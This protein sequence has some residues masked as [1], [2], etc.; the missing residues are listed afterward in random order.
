MSVSDY[1]H[2]QKLDSTGHSR[3]Q[4][5]DAAYHWLQE[6]P[7]N[8]AKINDV[9]ISDEE[10]P[11]LQTQLL[12]NWQQGQMA[13]ALLCLRC[14]VSHAILRAC[15]QLVSQFGDSYQFASTDLLPFVLD[16]DG[17]PL[18]AYQPLG[19]HIVETYTPGKTSLE[20]WAGHLTRNHSELNQFLIE[21]GLYRV[22]DW[23]I[24][25]DTRIE[26]LP[27]ILGEFHRLTASEIDAAKVL[28]DSYHRVY[29]R[30]RLQLSKDRKRGRCQVP[31]DRQ[32]QAIDPKTPPRIALSQLRQLAYW[33]R[34]YRI[35]VRG[36]APPAV[37]L[38]SED[39]WERAAP[40][41][42]DSEIQQDEFLQIYHQQFETALAEAMTVTLQAY[43]D[44]LHRKQPVKADKFL[45][46]LHL[47]H[48]EGKAMKAIAP[49]VGL[50][51]QVQ[52]TR[53]MNLRRFRADVRSELLT[54]LQSR[55]PDTVLAFTSPEQL[56]KI[57]DYLDALLAEEGDRLV[58]E[59]ES[60]AKIPYNRAANSRFAQ[61]LCASLR[62]LNSSKSPLLTPPC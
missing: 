48:C 60:E 59:A 43:Y 28:L 41:R 53:L 7:P 36:G 2:L 4:Q 45:K 25:N 62:H 16:D 42:S 24:L 46:A 51:N 50:T 9:E 40:E 18:G 55:L 39:G 8:Y 10:L 29:R 34:Q 49:Q 3:R 11:Q 38:D 20:G 47:F 5:L 6:Q 21:R 58:A 33:L 19:V 23:A 61:Q 14:L 44:K 17:Q 1:W 22:S 37:S 12:D 26:Q 13:I 31:S 54:R 32:L 30:D 56:M 15:L 52:V 27:K 57:G 35:Y